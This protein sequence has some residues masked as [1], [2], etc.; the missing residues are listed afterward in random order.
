MIISGIKKLFLET[1]K[2]RGIT[3]WYL[4]TNSVIFQNT[5]TFNN[6]KD[7]RTLERNRPMR[8]YASDIQNRIEHKTFGK[9]SGWPSSCY[10][11]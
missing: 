11:Q 9:Y 10:G 2:S 5:G 6:T 1:K 7:A 3:T 8:M 4:E